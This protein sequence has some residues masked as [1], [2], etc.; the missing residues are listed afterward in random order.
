MFKDVNLSRDQNLATLNYLRSI[1]NGLT[2]IAEESDYWRLNQEE[3][4]TLT[5][6]KE[7]IA[8]LTK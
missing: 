6:A 2:D 3:I 4:Q 7:I 8:K 5:E 1:I